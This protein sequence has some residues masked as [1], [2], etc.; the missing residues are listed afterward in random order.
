VS[1]AAGGAPRPVEHVKRIKAKM[2]DKGF[3]IIG[4]GLTET[5]GVGASNQNENYM[6][7]PDSTGRATPPIVEIAILD[8]DGKPVAQGERGE[9]CIRTIA[10]FEGYWNNADATK[11]AFTEDGFFRTGDIGRLDEEGYLFIVDRKKDIIIRGGENISCQE[12]EDAI[13]SHPGVSE[14]SVFSVPDDRFGEVPAMVFVPKPGSDLSVAALQ[15]YLR[16]HLAAFKVPSLGWMQHEPLPRL[17]TAKIDR[18][19]VAKTH[20]ERAAAEG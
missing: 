10:L 19:S 5:Q 7:R 13:Y 2:G 15:D 16:Q 20:R 14:A 4:Y 18:V 12:V 3:P 11:A 1:V 17:G 8:D 6:E 9:V